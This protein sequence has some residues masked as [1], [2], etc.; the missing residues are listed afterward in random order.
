MKDMEKAVERIEKAIENEENILVFGD[1]DVDGTTAVSLVS[2]YLKPIT[3]ML[4]PIYRI[5]MMRLRH[6]I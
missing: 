5:G 3:L 2:S 4:L 1:Y 6:F